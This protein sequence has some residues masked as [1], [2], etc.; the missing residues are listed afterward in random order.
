MISNTAARTA[1]RMGAK[2]V[3]STGPRLHKAKDAWQSIEA[4]RPVDPHPHVSLRRLMKICLSVV[5]SGTVLRSY[6]PEIELYPSL[7]ALHGRRKQ[8]LVSS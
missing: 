2:R 1:S 5:R 8:P 7:H 6:D 4:T 3:M